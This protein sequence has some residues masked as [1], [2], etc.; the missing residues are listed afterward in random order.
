MKGKIFKRE[1]D[2][3]EKFFV[4]LN[5]KDF[6]LHPQNVQEIE[7][8]ILYVDNVIGRINNSD[9]INYKIVKVDG[10]KTAKIV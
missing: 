1:I 8:A 4:S 3:K 2:N 10:I 7:D 5:E 9:N 6:P